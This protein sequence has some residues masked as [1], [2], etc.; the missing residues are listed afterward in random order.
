MD[1]RNLHSILPYI[2]SLVFTTNGVAVHELQDPLM[3][4]TT[5]T[6]QSHYSSVSIIT[7]KHMRRYYCGILEPK[8]YVA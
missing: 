7:M 5:I 8:A 1:G 2:S 3:E 6:R 4:R